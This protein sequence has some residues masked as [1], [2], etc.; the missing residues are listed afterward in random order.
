MDPDD[1]GLSRDDLI[2]KEI[3]AGA[4]GVDNR[5]DKVLRHLGVI[6]EKLLGVLGEAIAAIA[7]GGIVVM[8]A[9][10]RIEAH[11]VDDLARVQSARHCIAVKFVEIGDPHREIGVGEKLDRLGLIGAGKED[12]N[13]LFDRAFEEE[14]GEPTGLAALVADDDAARVKVVVKGTSLAE[15]FGREHHAVGVETLANVADKADGDGG[16]DDDRCTR[17]EPQHKADHALN[18]R[19]V[20]V[21]RLGVIVRGR[22]HNHEIGS[23]IGLFGIGGGR[24]A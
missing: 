10:P 23:G 4:V 11:P 12:G 15:E 2:G 24:E 7:E 18:A 19:G 13:V 9:D 20:K 3:L 16:F 14:I 5:A 17:I 6:R 21:V 22:R 1:F 8:C